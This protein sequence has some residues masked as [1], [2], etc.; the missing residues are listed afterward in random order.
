VGR[1]RGPAIAWHLHEGT[2]REVLVVQAMR[3]TTAAGDLGVDPED[4]LPDS[5]H[6]QTIAEKRFG[7]RWDRISRLVKID[8]EPVKDT[9]LKPTSVL[10]HSLDRPN[11]RLQ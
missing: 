8:P 5:F 10:V 6:L 4:V 9:K 7:L 3:P 2:F 11:P 1:T